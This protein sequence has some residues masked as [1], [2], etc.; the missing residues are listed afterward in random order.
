[1]PKITKIDI[2]RGYQ[3]RPSIAD[4]LPWKDY[5]NQHQCFLLED[6]VSLAMAFSIKPIACEARPKEMLE[7]MMRSIA[8]SLK[9]AIP[10]AKEYPWILQAF[11]QR[12]HNL[13]ATFEH[14]KNHVAQK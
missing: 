11:V 2:A 8:E 10:L 9:N 13:D 6:G 1:M 3:K 14:I 5:S 4:Y 7:A 12:T